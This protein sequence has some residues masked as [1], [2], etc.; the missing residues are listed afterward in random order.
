MIVL[1]LTRAI[2]QYTAFLFVL[3]TAWLRLVMIDSS[4]ESQD[5]VHVC[6]G[7]RKGALLVRN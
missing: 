4:T 7:K 6:V 1:L 2:S 3:K 5:F